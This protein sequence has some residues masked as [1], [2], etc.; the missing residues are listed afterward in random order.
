MSYFK[1]WQ[2][3]F[4]S[5]FYIIR[6]KES[7]FKLV[8]VFPACITCNKAMFRNLENSK[9]YKSEMLYQ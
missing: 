4:Y 3:L 7:G 1:E 9:T 6:V 2:E 8:I 5:L